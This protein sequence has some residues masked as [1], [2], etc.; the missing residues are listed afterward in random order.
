MLNANVNG[1]RLAYERH[2]NGIPAL[3]IHGHP[4]DHSI[5][6]PVI[7]LL[8]HE[9][10]LILPDLRGFGE[11]ETVSGSYL[12][13]NMAA[14][15][16]ALLDHLKV[17]QVLI[18]GHSMGGY[19][20]LAIARVQPGRIRGLGLVASQVFADP[21]ERKV[22]RYETAAGIE[23]DG[24]GGMANTFPAKLSA[25]LALLPALGAIIRRQSP[26][27]VAE[28]LRAIA[29]RPDSSDLLKQLT[30]PVALIHGKADQLI[31]VERAR[32]AHELAPRSSLVEIEGAGHMAMME[33]PEETSRALKGML[34]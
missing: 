7:P 4:L 10:D 9:F 18:A 16:L 3:L 28:S 34:R 27:G 33:A 19:V 15:L 23:K 24:V 20:A 5:W 22:A 21:P 12:L 13:D 29:E 30:C 6:T 1:I 2:G 32:Q 8:A 26:H 11:S 31:P 17:S 14:D 25:D